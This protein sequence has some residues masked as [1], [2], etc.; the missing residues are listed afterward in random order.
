[1]ARQVVEATYGG[2]SKHILASK[3]RNMHC[4]TQLA[5]DSGKVSARLTSEHIADSHA[6][7]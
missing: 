5:D 2:I 4:H 6:P 7:R 3:G 1:M